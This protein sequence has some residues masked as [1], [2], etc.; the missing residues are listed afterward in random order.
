MCNAVGNIFRLVITLGG[1]LA[2]ALQFLVTYDCAFLDFTANGNSLASLGLWFIGVGGE[3]LTDSSFDP[4][5][6]DGLIQGARSCLILSMIFGGG[7]LV[8]VIFEWFCC[9]ICCAGMIEGIGFAGAW[10]LGS[11][12]YMVYGLDICQ[13]PSTG[14]GIPGFPDL[15]SSTCEWGSGATFNICAVICWLGCG[16]LLCC[17][18][19]P[20]PICTK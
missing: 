4:P 8:L 12:V 7:A 3:C 14:V 20:E 15:S 2:L 1:L 9:Q 17:A 10:I 5:N 11:S 6:E 13:T 16:V 18:P 19:Q